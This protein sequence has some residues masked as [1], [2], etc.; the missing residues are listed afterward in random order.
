MANEPKSKRRE[1]AELTDLV[2]VLAVRDAVHFPGLINTLHVV[3]EAS[4]KALRTTMA[5]SRRVLV[6]SQ[7]DMS[8]EEPGTTDL[9]HLGT[10]SEA[11]QAIP[12]PDTSLRVA[13]RG[14]RRVKAKSIITKG[15]SLWA[16]IEEI[17]EVPA[18]DIETEALMRASLE[19]FTRVV[20]FSKDIP[21]EA[22]QG[23]AQIDSAGLLADGILHH[24]PIRPAQKQQLL[25]ELDHKKRLSMV[26]TLLSKEEQVLDLNSSIHKR[27]EQELGESQ[28][29]FYLREQLKIIESELE[30]REDRL[31]ETDDYRLKIERSGMSQ[32]AIE[33]ATVE[34]RRLDRSPPA[35]P[36]GMVVRNYLDTLVSLPWTTLTEDRLDVAAAAKL[37]DERHFGLE[38][39][40]DRIL[41]QLAV[42]QLRKSMRGP[43][44]CFVGPPGVGKTSIARSIADAMGRKFVR[45][46]LGGLRDEAE[47]R[48]HRRTYV[49]SLPGRIIQGIKDCG[50]RNPVILLDEVDKVAAG[51]QGDPTS[52]L[53]EALDAEQNGRFVDHYIETPFDLSAVLFIGTAN[54]MENVPSALRDR[55][56]VIPFG[57]YTQ[58]ERREIGQQF[59]LPRALEENGL[60]AADIV[61]T[62][63]TIKQLIEDYTREAGVRSLDRQLMAICRKAARRVAEG[64][65]IPIRVDPATAQ[66]F[67][68]RPRHARS[69]HDLEP[70]VGLAWGLVV[71][72]VGGETVAVEVTLSEPQGPRPELWLTGNLGDVMKESVQ[73][74]LSCIRGEIPEAAKAKDVHVHLPAAA[75][76]KEGPS[77]GLTV[78]VALASAYQNRPVRGDVAMTGEITLRGRVLP[79]G[80]VRDK[81]LAAL[82]AG[83]TT[84]I[85]PAE[86]GP[87][88]EDVP[89]SAQSQLKVH[90]IQT[91]AEA[92]A[93]AFVPG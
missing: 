14:L 24:L 48:G 33:R 26:L 23:I 3:R 89:A 46:A 11:L 50:T 62:P 6:L 69:S 7:I 64:A 25:E 29:E 31:G 32:E 92:L 61:V 1:S 90:L 36:E 27:V 93:L 84:I 20:Q 53:L 43:I 71:S 86:N 83:K 59:L 35:S 40:K 75:I 60:T 34:L 91:V 45:I 44:L 30:A 4:L 67:L 22:L 70:Q 12:L 41:D 65:A 42:R 8:V 5:G 56:E 52:A 2:P 85:L 88:L 76:P 10:L 74:A 68:G 79:V 16:E 51:A 58:E 28:R 39:V 13:L 19:C 82:A 21:P 78:A 66:E 18:E 9:F 15:G 37:L 54:L 73:T 49:G 55:M 17:D 87:D 81:L 38:R 57:S 77:A 63:E 47:I 80:G 72:E